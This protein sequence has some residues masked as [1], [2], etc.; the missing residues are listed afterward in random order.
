MPTAIISQFKST[1]YLN[2][3]KDKPENDVV[4]EYVLKAIN[5]HGI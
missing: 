5:A 1:L 4:I 3:A 2:P